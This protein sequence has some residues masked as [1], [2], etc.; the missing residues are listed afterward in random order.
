MRTSLTGPVR[1]DSGLELNDS[2][3]K[4]ERWLNSEYIFNIVLTGFKDDL[5]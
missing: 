3:G 4:G 1:A 2:G 5:M